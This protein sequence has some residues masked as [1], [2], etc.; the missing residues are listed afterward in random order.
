[1]NA[2]RP[3]WFD[4]RGQRVSVLPTAEQTLAEVEAQLAST[5][6]SHR[7]M[8]ERVRDRLRASLSRPAVS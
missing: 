2:E 4:S 3:A 5:D 8:L 1:M 7:D 6:C